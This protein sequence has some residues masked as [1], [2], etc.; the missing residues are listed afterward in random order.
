MPLATLAAR[1]IPVFRMLELL[2]SGSSLAPDAR[3]I[4]AGRPRTELS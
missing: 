1:P 4:V 2:P 3:D